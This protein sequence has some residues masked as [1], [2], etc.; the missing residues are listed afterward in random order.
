MNNTLLTKNSILNTKSKPHKLCVDKL[1]NLVKVIENNEVKLSN[2][3]V[4]NV[5]NQVFKRKIEDWMSGDSYATKIIPIRFKNSAIKGFGKETCY[6]AFQGEIWGSLSMLEKTMA[7]IWYN[8]LLTEQFKANLMYIKLNFDNNNYI[9]Y[10]TDSTDNNKNLFTINPFLMAEIPGIA[11]MYDLCE[12]NILNDIEKCAINYMAG[13]D[14]SE[15]KYSLVT[16]SNIYFNLPKPSYYD[17]ILKNFLTDKK[18]KSG[19]KYYTAKQKI[20]AAFF[21]HQP[22]EM[23]KRR[24]IKIMKEY[25]DTIE[26]TLFLKNNVFKIFLEEKIKEYEILDKWFNKYFPNQ[27]NKKIALKKFRECENSKYFDMFKDYIDE[28]EELHKKSK[29]KNQGDEVLFD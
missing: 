15:S 18:Q 6:F 24:I 22:L 20:A 3:E 13:G 8:D 5:T 29:K 21:G 10:N 1:D 2:M 16:L 19:G 14:I 9:L 12:I 17:E 4:K 26:D 7:T 28:I 23:V 11:I 25:M 27:Y